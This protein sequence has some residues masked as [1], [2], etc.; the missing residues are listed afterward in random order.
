M[1]AR[2]VANGDFVGWID[3]RLADADLA[4]ATD[5]AARLRQAVVEPL[6]HAYGVSNFGG[7]FGFAL[8]RI[9][10]PSG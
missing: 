2:D 3:R 8:I 9:A 1:T 4:S 6:T 5:R 7:G 10:R